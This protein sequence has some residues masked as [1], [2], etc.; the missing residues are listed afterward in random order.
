MENQS[1]F[2]SKLFK[3]LLPIVVVLGIIN[4]AKSG[5]LFGQWLHNVLN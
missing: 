5:Y 2:K 3:I 1:F 4:I